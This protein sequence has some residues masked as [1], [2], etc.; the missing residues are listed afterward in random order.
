[1]LIAQITDAHLCAQGE[2][3]NGRV[4]TGAMLQACVATLCALDPQPDAILFSGDLSDHGRPEEYRAL[5][6]L[7]APL[8]MPLYVIPGNHD[9]RAAFRQAF[10]DHSYLPTDGFLNYVIDRHPLRLIGLDTLV[11]GAAKGALSARHLDFLKSTL[12]EG[13][14]RPTLIFMHHPPFASGLHH[15][16]Q[17]GCDG[18]GA[19]ADLLGSFA[20]VE[21][22]VAGHQHR[23]IFTR[24]GGTIASVAPSL[25]HQVLLDL[26]PDRH[27]DDKFVMEPPAFHLHHWTPKDGVVTHH[28]Y[29]GEF[30]GPHDFLA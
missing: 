1:M 10:S 23:T 26:T 20:N 22:V 7:L 15:M 30:D 29:I 11:E 9:R 28:A 12:E 21:R 19:L 6:R 5:R 25:A 13:E 3:C 4:D 8:T 16:D 24:Y 17:T 18:A 27:P 14:D 2:L